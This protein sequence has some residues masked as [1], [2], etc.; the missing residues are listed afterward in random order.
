MPTIS[1]IMAVYNT[2]DEDV[3]RTS[4][5]SILNQTY[6]DF[7]FI[8]CEDGST[9]NTYSVLEKL[10]ANDIRIKL[11]KNEK[12]IKAG[13]A[14]NKCLSIAQGEFIAIMDADDYSHPARLEKQIAFLRDN[15]E[16]DFVGCKGVY[17]KHKP[18]KIDGEYW[19]CKY[20]QKQDF[21]ITLPF[22][23][24]SLMFKKDS[25]EKQKGYCENNLVIRSED[26]D[27]LLRL[28]AAGCRGANLEKSLYYIR[29]DD[30]TFKRRK[31]RFRVNEMIVK[32]RGFKNLGLMPK[33]IF[34]AIKPLVVG[35]I[36]VKIL[37]KI[38][39]IYYIKRRM[40]K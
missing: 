8:I 21:L 2:D 18:S 32:Y 19:F 5:Q 40:R 28:Y 38:K 4:I 10:C 25:I 26:Y 17:F 34:Y 33:G 27:L 12:N 29:Q 37:N 9:D 16:Y 7:E 24:G 20:P 14:R 13:G 30:N 15:K 11:L 36:P 22:V 35:L 1:V 39:T 23:H 31:Y 6:Q 3:L